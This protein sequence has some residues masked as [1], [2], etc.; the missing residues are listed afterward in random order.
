VINGLL[1]D[2][3]SL[4]TPLPNEDIVIIGAGMSGALVAHELCTAGFRCT[5]LDR[6]LVCSGSTWA[7]TAHL[8]YELDVSL[9]FLKKKY[10][11]AAAVRI[12]QAGLAAVS[13]VGEVLRRPVSMPGIRQSGA[14]TS[15]LTAKAQ[16]KTRRNFS[17][18][19]TM[20]CPFNS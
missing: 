17:C 9:G 5:M 3:P 15:P 8:N 4:S 20:V 7:S 2:Y 10:G 6:R 14:C 18:A 11:E 12:Y 1:G 13:R 16:N 19:S